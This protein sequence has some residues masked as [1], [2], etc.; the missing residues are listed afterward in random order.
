MPTLQDELKAAK[1]YNP[2]NDRMLLTNAGNMTYQKLNAGN[3]SLPN[4]LENKTVGM[5]PLGTPYYDS[6]KF[7]LNE[8]I[9]SDEYINCVISANKLINI[10]TTTIP[11]RNANVLQYVDQGGWDIIFNI[12]LVSDFG[13]NNFDEDTI[14][15]RQ[16]GMKK[17]SYNKALAGKI[18]QTATNP[19]SILDS[20]Q[21][22]RWQTDYQPDSKLKN[23][24]EFFDEFF[25]NPTWQNIKVT[26]KYLNNNLTVDRIIPYSIST[27]QNVDYTNQY[28]ITISCYSDIDADG[29]LYND[30]II[31]TSI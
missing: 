7:E 9:F 17:D 13:T 8:L 31:P 6:V 30:E 5:T 25:L 11:G 21:T 4:I 12:K 15:E 2:L 28:D 29:L 10:A 3:N 26:S 20:P 27:A 24:L 19:L 1:N 23:L 18:I 16:I 14:Q 22:Y